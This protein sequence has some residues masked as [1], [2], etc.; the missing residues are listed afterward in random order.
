MLSVLSAIL[1]IIWAIIITISLLWVAFKY[2]ILIIIFYTAVGILPFLL[3]MTPLYNLGKWSLIIGFGLRSSDY[4]LII[5][6]IAISIKIFFFKEKKHMI[7]NSNL[8]ILIALLG[9]YFLFEILRNVIKYKVAAFGEFRYTYITLILPIYIVYFFRSEAERIRLFKFLVFTSL[10]LTLLFIPIIGF[11]KNWYIHPILDPEKGRFLPSELSLGLFYGIMG[12]IIG[13][14]YEIFELKNFKLTLITTLATTVIILDG[15]RSVWLSIIIV[16]II[17]LIIRQKELRVSYRWIIPAFGIIT[18]IFLLISSYSDIS[19]FLSERLLAF[20]NPEQDP[21][22]NW[23]LLNWSFQIERFF[24]SPII[25]EGFGSY[26]GLKIYSNDIWIMP[27]NLYIMI[28]AKLGLIGLIL[29]LSINIKIFFELKNFLVKVITEN[30]KQA[31][32]I[33]LAII[34]LIGT[35]VYAVAYYIDPRYSWLF[36]G[37]GLAA[38][39]NKNEDEP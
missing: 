29:Y 31:A 5:M 6:L 34:S 26:W 1:I 35:N 33:T 23:R 8:F 2:P 27:H 21:T 9:M 22:A 17:L 38:V 28:L 32:I 7:K 13:K 25:G 3:Q 14:K 10:I 19:K 16:F 36:I 37:L 15:H 20:T 4:L 11:L 30:K 39:L 18:I 12:L 24:H